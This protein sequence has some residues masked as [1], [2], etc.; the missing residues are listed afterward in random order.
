MDKETDDYE[1]QKNFWE[2]AGETDGYSENVDFREVPAEFVGDYEQGVYEGI[3]KQKATE[4]CRR[5]FVLNSVLLSQLN[6]LS[7]SPDMTYRIITETRTHF[8][9]QI[10][11]ID[12][13]QTRWLEK[14]YCIIFM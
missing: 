6:I 4:K 3:S 10:P 2:M 11:G 1:Y 7:I 5:A 9:L 13:L 8:Y 14:K 12:S